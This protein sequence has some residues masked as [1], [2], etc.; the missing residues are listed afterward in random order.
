MEKVGTTLYLYMWCW[1]DLR[2]GRLPR[3]LSHP[4][5]AM[6]LLP[7]GLLWTY[8]DNWWMRRLKDECQKT[9]MFPMFPLERCEAHGV[10]YPSISKEELQ[11]RW[12]I[13]LWLSLLLWK[14]HVVWCLFFSADHEKTDRKTH[15]YPQT[16]PP[17]KCPRFTGGKLLVTWSGQKSETWRATVAT[18]F[19]NSCNR[20]HWK[21]LR[22]MD[23]NHLH[24][25]VFYKAFVSLYLIIGFEAFQ[26]DVGVFFI[27]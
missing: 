27:V 11:Q 25:W 22:L 10:M 26:S 18:H 7:R 9:T 4:Q 19:D 16:Q 23:K 20:I 14:L 5:V 21:E 1:D 6:L 3:F 2:M 13:C 12:G 8:G 15:I 17:L 24:T